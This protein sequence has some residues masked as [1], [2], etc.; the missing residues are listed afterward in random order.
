LLTQLSGALINS[1]VSVRLPQQV[2][3]LRKDFGLGAAVSRK[4]AVSV[5]G[6]RRHALNWRDGSHQRPGKVQ[7]SKSSSSSSLPSFS[8]SPSLYSPLQ[9]SL[10][11][12]SHL[13]QCLPS[14][15]SS[16][17]CPCTLLLIFDVLTFFSLKGASRGLGFAYAKALLASSPSIR[18]IA[19]ARNLSKAE[20]LTALA[21]EKENEGRLLV[22]ALDVDDEA[23][24]KVR[25]LFISFL[26][27]L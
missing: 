22:L 17:V 8:S 13:Q 11:H 3:E 15:T 1:E 7:R 10:R 18:V 12:S 20:Q 26:T 4:P 27:S 21:A 23:A 2:S 16:P 24:V 19:T 25:P 6:R 9:L 14:P 5:E